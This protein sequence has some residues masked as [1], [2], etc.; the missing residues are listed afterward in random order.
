MAHALYINQTSINQINKQLDDILVE[1]AI[2]NKKACS[3]WKQ[4]YLKEVRS[5]PPPP[6]SPFLVQNR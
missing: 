6:S 4:H 5:F 2:S 3:F 1:A